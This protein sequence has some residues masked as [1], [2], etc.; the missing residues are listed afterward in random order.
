MATRQPVL[1]LDLDGTLLKP[2]KEFDP[3]KFAAPN[4]DVVRLVRRL[5]KSGWLIAL[6]TCRKVSAALRAYLKQQQIPIDFFNE[7]PGGPEG[8]PK[9][10]ADVYLDDRAVR[11]TGDGDGMFDLI[12][13]QRPGKEMEKAAAAV[14]AAGYMQSRKKIRPIRVSTLVKKVERRRVADVVKKA[15]Q[16]SFKEGALQAYVKSAPYVKASLTAAIPAA[17]ATKLITGS[18][19]AT[20]IIGTGAVAAGLVDRG[21]KDWAE[22][23]KRRRLAKIVRQAQ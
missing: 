12:N 2:P 16:D 6:W 1:A 8:S 7:N 11:Y 21:I 9:I 18:G 13:K 20:K 15:A 23:H 10:F 17:L 22:K 3:G 4:M 5:K 14:R 19:P